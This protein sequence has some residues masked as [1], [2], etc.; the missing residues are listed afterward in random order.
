MKS[1]VKQKSYKDLKNVWKKNNNN[2][3]KT[4]NES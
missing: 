3:R 1:Y 4:N 2:D